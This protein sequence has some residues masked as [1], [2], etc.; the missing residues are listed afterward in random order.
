MS[1]ADNGVK[2]LALF[3]LKIPEMSVNKRSPRKRHARKARSLHEIFP[4]EW[5]QGIR[6]LIAEKKR[7]EDNLDKTLGDLSELAIRYKALGALSRCWPWSL[8]PHL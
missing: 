2:A 6:K 5:R 8:L 1:E 7:S 4:E 3:L